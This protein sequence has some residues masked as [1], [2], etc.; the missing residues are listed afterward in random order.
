ME[1]Y[2]IVGTFGAIILAVGVF[3]PTRLAKVV[4][5]ISYFTND[6]TA[7]VVL[8][9][10]AAI[11]LLLVF[12]GTPARLMM[13]GLVTLLAV[14][15]SYLRQDPTLMAVETTVTNLAGQAP[16]L[17]AIKTTAAWITPTTPWWM[18]MAGSAL[19]VIAGLMEARKV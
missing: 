15:W 9:A 4:G 10:L 18:M 19:L 2:K 14:T 3:M 12:T 13:F 17:P 5:Y 7:A 16:A 8:V 6:H 1:G 11:A